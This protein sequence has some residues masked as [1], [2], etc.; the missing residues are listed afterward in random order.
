MLAVYQLSHQPAT[1]T[2][3]ACLSS[4]QKDIPKICIVLEKPRF[5][6]QFKQFL[7]GSKSVQY[8]LLA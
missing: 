6:R 1:I 7:S 2:C 3:S 8:L 5:S 4:G